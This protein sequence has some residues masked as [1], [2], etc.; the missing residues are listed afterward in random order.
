MLATMSESSNQHPFS[1]SHRD[2]PQDQQHN[3]VDGAGME[4]RLCPGCKKS[5]V[6]EEGGLVVAF[7]QSFFHVECFKCAKCGDKVTADTNLLLLSDGSPICANCSYSCNICHL[8]ILDE[9]IM[10]G[11]DSYHAHC[12]K[13]KICK[14]RIDDLVFAKTSQGIYCMDCHNERMIKIRKHNERK[15]AQQ[16][17]GGSH[18]RPRTRDNQR[19]VSPDSSKY[20][21]SP[22]RNAFP[23]TTRSPDPRSPPKRITP[24]VSDAFEPPSG[25]ASPNYQANFGPN[26]Q[27]V[28]DPRGPIVF[29]PPPRESSFSA[30]ERSRLNPTKQNTLPL[31]IS[32]DENHNR[33][34]SSSFDDG[35]RAQEG[36]YIN[37][38]STLDAPSS[39]KDKRRSI[40]PGL[41][42]TDLRVSN[43]AA[44][45]TLS[46]LSAS[47]QPNRSPTSPTNDNGSGR[48]SNIPSPLRSSPTSRPGSYGSFGP[49]SSSS[50]QQHS[51]SRQRK[52]SSGL[53]QTV[54]V[55][56]RTSIQEPLLSPRG[57]LGDGMDGRSTSRSPSPSGRLSAGSLQKSNSRPSS[58]AD[59]PHSVESGTDEDDFTSHQNHMRNESVSSVPP[60]PP[61]KESASLSRSNSSAP[62]VFSPPLISSPSSATVEPITDMDSSTSHQD[63]SDDMSESSPVEAQSHATFIAPALP[64]IRFS[65]NSA[66]FSDL[67]NSVGGLPSLKSLSSMSEVKLNGRH[68]D[69]PVPMTPPPSAR[70]FATDMASLTPTS[71]ITIIGSNDPSRAAS[72]AP[73]DEDDESRSLTL[74]QTSTRKASLEYRPDSGSRSS[75]EAALVTLTTPGQTAARVLRQDPTDLVLL[76][77]QEALSDATDRGAQQLKLDRG[78]VEAIVQSISS[79]KAENADLKSKFD[80]AKRVSKQYIEGLTVAQTEYDRELKA[81]RDSEAEVTRLRVLLSG[82]AARLTA[83]TG[84]SRRQELRQQMTKEIHENL[85]GLERDL[86][87]LKVQRDITLAEV[88]ELSASKS[89]PAT[90]EP[91][92]NLGRTLTV[93]LDKLKTQYQRE[94]VP[95]TEQREALAREIMELKAVRDVFLEETTVLNAR[96]EELAQLS[97]QYTRR[98][99]AVPENSSMESYATPRKTSEDRLRNQ[100]QQQ[101]AQSPN[102]PAADD[103]VDLR[104]LKTPKAENELPTPSKKFIKWPTRT[105]KE[106]ANP[107]LSDSRGK[108]PSEHNFQQMSI[109]RFTRCDQCQEKM[110]GSQLRCATCSISVHVR[111]VNHVQALCSQ[112]NGNREDS[113]PMPPSMFGRDLIEQVEADAKGNGRHVPIIVEKCI[114]AVEAVALDYE[115]IYR[116]T[117][118]TGQSRTITQ[119]FERGDYSAF[120][121]CD[122]DR[123]NDICSV[124]SVLKTYFR[125]LPTPLLTYEL[126]DRFMSAV[127]IRDSTT[128]NRMLMELVNKLPPE[129]Y[130]TLRALM[131]HLHRIFERAEKNLMNA[132]N[133]GV[134]F[135]PTLMRSPNPGA[136]FSDMAGKALSIEWLVENAPKIFS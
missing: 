47:F 38:G 42:L 31:P 102:Y 103:T 6:T 85:S 54:T 104:Y 30:S 17:Q 18:S 128:K 53:D 115:G 63:S 125:N 5:A 80:G 59:V 119:L 7:G 131:L 71:E 15:A 127:E 73:Y 33:P 11:D 40:N 27:S 61:P 9:A 114:E 122:S 90:P 4:D 62:P 101:P 96:N 87:S 74:S 112:H 55:K 3:M 43:E 26:S 78:F 129:H 21:P 86:S 97:A 105:N 123:F 34:R 110:W 113:V 56:P 2:M 50:H 68:K 19:P 120:D 77:L 88:E 95:L 10:T 25:S 117:G 58:R 76:R 100:M 92:A 108:P 83:L 22:S 66:D 109:L 65:M 39:R 44:S 121:L 82:Q 24:Y 133:L 57:A 70:S 98:M 116:K 126:H 51:E 118:G 13:C 1:Q 16:A 107:S 28:A 37:K 64:P 12:F 106:A 48:D 79:Q 35:T 60:A 45:P 81:R 130:C 75:S 134:V 72:T 20:A 136:E 124:T 111:C 46:P 41:V 89:A 93:R 32:P 69:E 49:S 132:R 52:L 99:D 8:P 23:D 94:L 135:G 84:D 29:N 91:S 67:F 36:S 14:N